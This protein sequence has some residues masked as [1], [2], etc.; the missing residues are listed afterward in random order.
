M[1]LKEL[2][3]RV[4]WKD[5]KKELLKSYPDQKKSIEGYKI[6]FDTLKLKKPKKS[7][8]R[9][10]VE[11]VKDDFEKEKDVYYTHVSGK[12]GETYHEQWKAHP[13]WYP[14]EPSGEYANNEI[15]WAI[16]FEKWDKWIGM[17]ID[18]I[19]F[20]DHN[21]VQVVAHCLWEMTWMGF[22]EDKIQN[23]LKGIK[24]TKKEY[25]EI[26]KISK[27]KQK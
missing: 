26:R 7:K 21:E 6:I 23:T 8:M 13:N 20:K 19:S 11:K 16:E 5:V 14:E 10:C 27:K 17:E 25:E 12:N 3:D 4:E 1:K 24:V 22:T 15:G 18:K 2:I 9:I